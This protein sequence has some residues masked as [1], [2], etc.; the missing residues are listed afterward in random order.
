VLIEHAA[1]WSPQNP[2]EFNDSGTGKQ[3]RIRLVAFDDIELGR[4]Q[5]HLVKGLIPRTGLIVVWGPPKSGKS[6]WT[7]DVVMHVALDRPYRGRRVDH[8][9]V[10]YCAF[11]GQTGIEAR[12]AAFR[13]RFLAAEHER[14]QFYLEPIT[15]DL[16]KAAPELTAAIRG[17]L[18]DV[19][20]AVI[21]LD[22]LNR[23]LRGSESSD[24]DMT[25]YVCAA[26]MLRES[27]DCAV[28]IVHHC[29][30][31]G[32]R[33]RGHTSLTGAA[34]AQLAVNRDVADNI[35]VTLEYAKDGPQG[36]TVTSRLEVVEVGTDDDGD[37]I[38]SCVIVPVGDDGVLK[39]SKPKPKLAPIPTAA[40]RALFDLAADGGDPCPPSGRIP[41][42]VT[43][44]TLN[45]WREHLSKMQLINAD[46]SYREQFRRIHVTLK[47]AGVIGIWED[48]VWPVT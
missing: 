16:V 13:K 24:E 22:T 7:F 46:K 40:L 26:D 12:C 4:Q 9:A 11:E 43:C 30:I 33:P 3:S 19:N 27:F 8:G 25:A 35:I 21:V 47:N 10:V 23:S 31:D 36:D 45:R 18:G 15:P 39:P 5:R 38:T 2:A 42:G 1:L 28:I 44:V 17:T 34:D 37:P 14:V 29:G 32:S 41:R 48:F 6:F 20:P